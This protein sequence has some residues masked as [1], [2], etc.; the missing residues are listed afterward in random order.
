MAIYYAFGDM[1]N[2]AD[3]TE[4][5]A[6]AA[7]KAMTDLNELV[8]ALLSSL[9]PSKPWQRH[10]RHLL[11]EVDRTLQVLR[12][13]I[14][15]K[16]AADELREAQ[17]Q[18]RVALRLVHQYVRVGRADLGTKAAIELAWHLGHRIDSALS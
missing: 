7:A 15:L 9:S 4:S 10:L 16:R 18:L 1:E 14:T 17:E 6:A 13:T 8:Q 5:R 12:M 3:L 11:V 2:S